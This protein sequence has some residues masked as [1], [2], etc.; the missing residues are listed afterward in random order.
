MVDTPEGMMAVK[1]I[2]KRLKLLKS[3]YDEKFSEEHGLPESDGITPVTPFHK[4]IHYTV[5]E[6]DEFMDSSNMNIHD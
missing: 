6:F 1:G 4:R 2:I 3:L 5:F